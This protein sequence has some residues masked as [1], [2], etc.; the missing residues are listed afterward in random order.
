MPDSLRILWL[1]WRDR[2]HPRS[3]GAE[4]VNEE[5]ARRLAARGHEVTFLVGGFRGGRKHDRIPAGNGGSCRVIRVGGTYTVYIA[6]LVHY[7]RHLRG[8][9]DVVIDECNTM[10]FFAGWYTRRPTI[11][12]F[13]ML[14]REIWFQ[15]FSQPFSTMGWLAEPVYLRLLK[16]GPI[17]TVSESTRTDLMRCGFPGDAIRLISE[18]TELDPV[19]NLASIRKFPQPTLLSLG[20]VR[21]MKRTLDQVDAFELA[22]RRVPDLRLVLAGDCSGPYGRAVEQ[23]VRRS[24]HAADIEMRGHVSTEEKAELMR[25]A[26]LLTVT[27]IKEGWGLVVT[28]AASQGTPSVVYD[29]DG[30]RDSVRD[31]ETGIV[32]ARNTPAEL[33]S[34]AVDLL[35]DRGRYERL[36]AA[37]WEWSKTITF[38]RS[39]AD[40]WEVVAEAVSRRAITHPKRSQVG[41]GGGGGRG[42]SDR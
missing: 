16:R 17:V 42:G 38:D 13:H 24:V 39:C 1:N 7:L 2:Q 3:G 12:F 34:N 6:A 28:E 35:L 23:R 33:A 9:P 20:A 25:R 10:P 30:L 5:I 21:P 14:C 29:V 19:P 15:Q 22:K 27:S 32:C 11:L 37:G 4:T 40:L 31:G 18:G 36:R 8:W 26:H 41:A